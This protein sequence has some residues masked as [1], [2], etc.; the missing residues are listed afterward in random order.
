[1]RVGEILRLAPAVCDL[2]RLPLESSSPRVDLS[3]SRLPLVLLDLDCNFLLV[4]VD[5]LPDATE[6]FPSFQTTFIIVPQILLGLRSL[7]FL[8][9][10]SFRNLPTLLRLDVG[11]ELQHRMQV[12]YAL[13]GCTRSLGDLALELILRIANGFDTPKACSPFVSFRFVLFGDSL[14]LLLMGLHALLFEGVED[15]VEVSLLLFGEYLGLVVVLVKEL[16]AVVLALLNR[17]QTLTRL[18]EAAVGRSG[19]RLSLGL[20]GTVVPRPLG[21]LL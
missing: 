16:V 2:C 3:Q 19:V 9:Q 18:Q 10:F 20:L 8:G 21:R 7:F 12:A 15:A 1:M 13:E 17:F 11:L 14:L 5:E 6:I 4:P